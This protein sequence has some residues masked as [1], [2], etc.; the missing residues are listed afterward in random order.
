[1]AP[2]SREGKRQGR[3]STVTCFPQQPFVLGV[4]SL[5]S[6]FFKAGLLGSGIILKEIIISVCVSPRESLTGPLWALGD[7]RAQQ[8]SPV[9]CPSGWQVGVTRIQPLWDFVIQVEFGSCSQGTR[10]THR[11]WSVAGAKPLP[12]LRQSVPW[13]VPTGEGTVTPQGQ[14]E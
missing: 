10:C 9:S 12:V 4:M 3:M 14:R 13:A 11:N 8:K 1:M 6:G 5:N 2:D 7:G